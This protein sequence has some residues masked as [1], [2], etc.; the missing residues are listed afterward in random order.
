ML[1]GNSS[2]V[3]SRGGKVPTSTVWSNLASVES[4][5]SLV[6]ATPAPVVTPTPDL[7]MRESSPAGLTHHDPE[8]QVGRCSDKEEE[9][10]EEEVEG[11]YY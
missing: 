6:S 10:A 8:Q 3:T 7:Q 4:T 5:A 2:P 9:E 11:V 1:G